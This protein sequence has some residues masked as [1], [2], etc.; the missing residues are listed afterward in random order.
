MW[1]RTVKG[2]A[3]ELMDDATTEE[4]YENEPGLWEY[5]LKGAPAM[6]T[7]NIQPTKF[8]TN[9]ASG[10]MH[11]LSFAAGQQEADDIDLDAPGYREIRLDIPPRAVN[12]QLTL[13]DDD[14]GEG[15]QSLVEG[16]T[17]V[18]I[19][20]SRN[21]ESYKTHSLFASVKACP[22]IIRCQSFAIDLAFAITDFKLQGKTKDELILSVAPRPFPPHMDLKGLYVDISRLRKQTGL[23]VLHKP[24]QRRGGLDHLL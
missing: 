2:R 11:S 23:R 16:A 20:R 4:L 13:P 15:I 1:K 8:L 19:V 21:I 24:S 3:L 22:K 6:L 7:E 14:N 17:V 12:F 9:G 5:F 18:P 10:Y